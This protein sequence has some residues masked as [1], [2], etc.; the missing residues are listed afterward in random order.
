[1][2]PSF[3]L[4]IIPLL[5]LMSNHAHVISLNP[6]VPNPVNIVTSP[7]NISEDTSLSGSINVGISSFI[8]LL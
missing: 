2:N 3:P 4:T 6:I 8:P 1:M 5:I 7:I